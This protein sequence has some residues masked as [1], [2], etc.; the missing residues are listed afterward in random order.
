MNFPFFSR[1]VATSIFGK[2]DAFVPAFRIESVVLDAFN[3]RALESGKPPQEFLRDVMA[4]VGLG[5]DHVLRLHRERVDRVSH[6][7]GE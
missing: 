7:L 2:R 5:K 1:T 6:L 4:V 3:K